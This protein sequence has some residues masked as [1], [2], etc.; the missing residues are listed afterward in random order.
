MNRN[1]NGACAVK[2]HYVLM[3]VFVRL[4]ATNA[5]LIVLYWIRG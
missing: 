5:L 3:S 4:A 1:R 2:L